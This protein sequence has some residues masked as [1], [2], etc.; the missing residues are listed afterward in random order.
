M[1]DNLINITEPIYQ[2]IDAHKASMTIF[3][4]S[5]IEAFVTENN[6]K[7]TNKIIKQ[8]K[9]YKKNVGLDKSYDPYKVAYKVMPS[10]ASSNPEIKQL[11]INGH[12][13]Y[14]FKFGMIT[15]GLVLLGIFL[16]IIKILLILIL[17]FVVD[18][19]SDCL[20]EDKSLSDQR[21]LSLFLSNFFAKHSLIIPSVFIG[22]ATFDTIDIYKNLLLDIPFDKAYINILFIPHTIG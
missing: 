19:K 10:H 13:C 17:I 4:T 1:S 18:K 15:N 21:H 6:P 20:D 9:A 12:F 3:D 14:V 2:S 5:E 7:S 16:F 22:D 11:Y 8:L